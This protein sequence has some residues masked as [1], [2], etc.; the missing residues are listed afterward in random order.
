MIDKLALL[1]PLLFSIIFVIMPF[2]Q[3]AGLIP[4]VQVIMPFIVICALASLLYFIFKLIV[5]KSEVTV[6]ILSPLLILFFNYG[7]LYEYISSQIGVTKL[8]GPILILATLF[9]LLILIV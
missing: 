5:K 2:T 4:P 7:T 3:Y 8:K 1:H 9:I 6:A